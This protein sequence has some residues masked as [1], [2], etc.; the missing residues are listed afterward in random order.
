M[1]RS[2]SGK[3]LAVFLVLICIL[4]VA[5]C[6]VAAIL[7]PSI[8]VGV[9][10]ITVLNPDNFRDAN[11]E[12]YQRLSQ[13][14]IEILSFSLEESIQVE[15]GGMN[16]TVIPLTRDYEHIKNQIN[17]KAHANDTVLVYACYEII[18]GNKE[19]GRRLLG[20]L[21]SHDPTIRYDY[22]SGEKGIGGGYKNAYYGIDELVD[23]AEKI[24]KGDMSKKNLIE[25]PA[26]QYEWRGKQYSP[27][28]SQENRDK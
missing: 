19:L 10:S 20:L 25:E 24:C 17:K 28:Q 4:V 18:H 27:S 21:Q 22:S 2:G 26:A 8:I 9:R 7:G 5:I 14:E 15:C 11:V 3:K 23:A 12:F 13:N 6:V 1:N 16:V